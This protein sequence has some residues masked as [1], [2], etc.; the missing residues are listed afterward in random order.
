MASNLL[1]LD[2]ITNEALMVLHQKLNFVT[3]IVTD[4]DDSFAVE[5]AKIGNTLRVRLPMEYGTGTGST[6]TTGAGADSL[7]NQVTLTV[8]T[9]RHV[10]MRFT[11]NEMTMKIDDFRERHLEPAMSRL[12]AMIEYDALN[13]MDEVPNAV[14]AG[15]KVDFADIL[16]AGVILDDNLAPR[17]SRNA[18]LDSQA[19]A[20]C[21]NDLKGLFHDQKEVSRQYKEGLMGRTGGFDF[22]QNTLLHSHTSGAEGGGS[23]Y[24][25]NKATAQ[26]GSY[27]SPNSMSLIVDT[28]TKTVKE[29]DVFTIEDVYDV[30]PETKQSTGVLKQFTVL[31]D[32]TGAG[33]ISI[34]PAIIAS[35]RYQNCSTSAA[36]DKK[37]TFIGAASTA[38][39]Q[40][41]LFQKGFA[42]FGTADL[43]LP[44]NTQASRANYDGISLRLVHDAYDVVKDRLYTRLDVLYG[45]KVLRPDLAVR[46]QHT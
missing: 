26:V 43:V 17:D 3:N 13:M 5:G 39:K 32:F 42:V 25:T 6:I 14:S 18:L 33:T 35:G 34:S 1:T 4:Y 7:Q 24:L 16:Q 28:G 23:A 12:A 37:L 38:Y 46:V 8:N 19:N 20:D 40:S 22:Y 15:T 27:T 45:Y 11:S 31:A 2:E 10:P 29:G 36:N 30:H 9:Q 44:P 41:L 21:I